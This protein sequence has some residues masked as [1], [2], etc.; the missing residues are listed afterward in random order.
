MHR[1][2]SVNRSCKTPEMV[3][4]RN[5]K[6]KEWEEWGEFSVSEENYH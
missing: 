5:S 3:E 2:P 4:N 1:A 6:E